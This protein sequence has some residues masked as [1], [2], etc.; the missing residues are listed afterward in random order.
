MKVYLDNGATTKMAKEVVEAML[1]YLTEKYGNASS[2][3]ALGQEASKALEKSRAVIAKKLNAEPEEIIFTSGGSE[4]NNLAIKGVA[5]ANKDKG[6]HIITTKIEHSAVLE[7]CKSLEKE[8]FNVTYLDVDKDGFVKLDELRKAITTKTILVSIMAANNEIGTIQPLAEIG[9][10]CSERDVLFHTDAVQAFTKT[11]LDVEKQRISLLS[12][13]AHKLHGP[14]GMGALYIKKGTRI[15]RL[16]DGGPQE[17]KL[18]AGTENVAG[19]VAFAKAAQL[20]T[21]KDIARMTKLRD[22]L[23]KEILKIPN[24]ML[25]G[26]QK[27]RLCNNVNVSFKYVEGESLLM[28]LDEL[29]IAVS[30]GSACSSHELKPSH[31]LLAIGRSHVDAH[32]SLRFTLS[33]YTA[34][35]EIDYLLKHLPKIVADLRKIS[36]LTKK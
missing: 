14:K 15:K 11:E 23:I 12:L 36:P 7:T 9:K 1:P 17:K 30:T 4:S 21:K 34:K 19:I 8:G 3:Y 35:R 29:G 18:R 13:S 10:I 31:V 25:N 26:S 2:L 24:T 22:C 5:Y 20:I 33:K 16:I 32:G 27:N 28:K 6:N